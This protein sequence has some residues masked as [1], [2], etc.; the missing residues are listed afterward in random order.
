[1]GLP[2]GHFVVLSGYRE[3]SREVRV[4]DPWHPNPVSKEGQ[5]WVGMSRLVNSILLGI[6]TYDANLLII[7]KKKPA[8]AHPP[9]PRSK[10]PRRA[11]SRRRQ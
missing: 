10:D 2:A 3:T 5:Y 11:Y 9:K 6:L 1:V 4:A 8:T 7:D